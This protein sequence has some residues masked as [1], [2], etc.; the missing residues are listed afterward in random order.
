MG[1]IR[2]GRKNE[3]KTLKRKATRAEVKLMGA[4]AVVKKGRMEDYGF[5][6]VINKVQTERENHKCHVWK[7]IRINERG[8]DLKFVF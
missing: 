3:K 4:N 2:K 8:F 1:N 6:P 7:S 5:I